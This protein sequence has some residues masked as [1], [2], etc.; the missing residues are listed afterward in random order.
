MKKIEIVYTREFVYFLGILWSDGFIERSRAVL[1]IVEEDALQIVNDIKKIDFLNICT[2]R[3]ER[4]NRRPQMSIYFCNTKFYDSYLGEHFINKSIRS[5]NSLIEEIPNDLKRYFFLGLVDG[6]GCFYFNKKTRQFYITSSYDQDWSHIINLFNSIDVEQYEVK[7]VVNKKGNR[8][9]Y[10]RVKKH[11]EINNIFNFLYPIGYEMGLKRKFL[12]C[13][14]IIDNPPK[15][16]SNK[17]K[18]NLDE[19][20]CYIQSG[21]TIH[22]ISIKMKCNWRKI[23]NFCKVNNISK[24]RGFYK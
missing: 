24:P 13:K 9:S 16:S 21:L 17:S 14:D 3:R 1:E 7:K 15:Y 18:I 4:K 2:M 12:K 10:I 22:E 11:D 23:H 6:D 5:P 19:L 20:M 8:S